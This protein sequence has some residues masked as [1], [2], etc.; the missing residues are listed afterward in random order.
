MS[1]SL[2][3]PTSLQNNGERCNKNAASRTIANLQLSNQLDDLKWLTGRLSDNEHN[4]SLMWTSV[5][6]FLFFHCTNFFPANFFIHFYELR[7]LFKHL[8]IKFDPK[9]ISIVMP[10]I[11][12]AKSSIEKTI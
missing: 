1:F 11:V 12:L 10:D 2:R 9:Q 6:L 7:P 4:L 8:L 5:I 3:D